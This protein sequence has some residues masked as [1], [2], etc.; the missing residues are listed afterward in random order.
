MKIPNPIGRNR[1]LAAGGAAVLVVL[2]VA[3]IALLGGDDG[4]DA[5][6]DAAADR[7][8]TTAA[9]DDDSAAG[10][11]DGSDGAEDAPDQQAVE[12][13]T[14][15][16]TTTAPPADDPPADD[17]AAT[18][19]PPAAEEA[20]DDDPSGG[21]EGAN[22][23]QG[24]VVDESQAQS[25]PV[26]LPPGAQGPVTPRPC[27]PTGPPQR[28]P[29]EVDGPSGDGGSWVTV[30]ALQGN[31]GAAGGSF[32]TSGVDTRLVFRS[33]AEQMIVFVDDVDE[34]DASAGYADLECRASCAG[35][36]ILVNRAGTYRLRV[37][38]TDG[39]WVVEIQEY[40]R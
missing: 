23:D 17:P 24:G 30:G 33:D 36:R 28:Q 3:V 22:L 39:P 8:T 31:C 29:A 1:W 26:T 2:L 12:G 20:V 34:D 5:T 7:P 37:Q 9:A 32:G 16:P 21:G 25:P 38:A 11:G 40:R 27:S 4:T 18:T 10:S 13:T 15:P 19:V 35:T 6:T 14:V